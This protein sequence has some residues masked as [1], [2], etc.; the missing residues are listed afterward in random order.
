MK[1]DVI[2]NQDC[3]DFTLAMLQMLKEKGF[4]VNGVQE[5]FICTRSIIEVHNEFEIASAE[6]NEW[7]S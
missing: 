3:V 2:T 4:H 6:E 7:Q 1:G 5:A